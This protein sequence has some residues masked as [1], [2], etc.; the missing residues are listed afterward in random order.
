M[1]KQNVK[2]ALDSRQ[3]GGSQLSELSSVAEMTIEAALQWAFGKQQAHRSLRPERIGPAGYA[4]PWNG[5]SRR[6]ALGVAVDCYWSGADVDAP[7]PDEAVWIAE[8]VAALDLVVAA[9]VI[10]HARAGT[11]PELCEDQPRMVARLGYDEQPVILRDHHRWI[12]SFCV[13]DLDPLP[14]HREFC[15]Q[16][17]LLWWDAL[18]LLAT[19]CGYAKLSE[20]REPWLEKSEATP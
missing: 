11:R 9:L 1:L 14:E 17:W 15:R 10:D 19:Q 4:S 13:V 2:M 6:H 3:T 8:R 16:R 20:P 5:L 18:S 12:G 7:M